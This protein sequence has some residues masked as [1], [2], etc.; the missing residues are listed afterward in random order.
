MAVIS[1]GIKF[2]VNSLRGNEP[3]G[4]IK[5]DTYGVLVPGLQSIGDLSGLDS[6]ST[7]DKIEIT[8][9]ADDKHVYADGIQASGEFDGIDFTFLYDSEIFKFLQTEANDML[10]A[11]P[12]GNLSVRKDKWTVLIP[13]G[14]ENKYEAFSFYADIDALKVNSVSVN[15]A[16]TMTMS[17]KPCDKINVTSVTATLSE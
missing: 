6:S 17:L 5:H 8:T 9:L 11:S 15:S 16:L 2:Y 12:V 3:A 14:G 10:S 1:K 13:V 7:R 4:A